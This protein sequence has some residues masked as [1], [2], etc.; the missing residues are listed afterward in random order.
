MNSLYLIHYY[1]LK[2][3]LKKIFKV[4]GICIPAYQTM[5]TD[6]RKGGKKSTTL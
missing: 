5:L 3:I 6:I 4:F 2:H 1:T